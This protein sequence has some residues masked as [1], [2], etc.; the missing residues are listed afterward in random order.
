[1]HPTNKLNILSFLDTEDSTTCTHSLSN[2]AGYEITDDAITA[3][4]TNPHTNCRIQQGRMT[5]SGPYSTP[6][7]GWCA[8]IYN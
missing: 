5:D 3:S 8:G 7:N 2:D 1:M 6:G 4:S